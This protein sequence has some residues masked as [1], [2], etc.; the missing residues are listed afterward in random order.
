MEEVDDGDEAHERAPPCTPPPSHRTPPR[1]S[2]HSSSVESTPLSSHSSHS[3]H[4]SSSS[5][6][7]VAEGRRIGQTT[8]GHAASTVSAYKT[9]EKWV[10]AALRHLGHATRDELVLNLDSSCDPND[11]LASQ[12]I[13]MV[14]GWHKARTTA[15]EVGAVCFRKADAARPPQKDILRLVYAC[16]RGHI[17]GVRADHGISMIPD[18]KW[19]QKLAGARHNARVVSENNLANRTSD[20]SAFR[21][22]ADVSITPQQAMAMILPAL[23][24]NRRV[25][26]DPLNAVETGA[27]FAVFLTTGA[28]T[29]E[30][31]GCHLQS[32]GVETIDFA[33]GGGTTWDSVFF[34]ALYTKTGNDHR[35]SFLA[36]SNP[37]MCGVGG[38]GMSIL[39]R[40]ARYGHGPPLSM[41]VD[42]NSWKLFV[43]T[44][45]TKRYEK[46]FNNLYEIARVA[47]QKRDNLTYAGRHIGT[48]DLQH[49]GGTAEGG[50][51]RRNHKQGNAAHHYITIPL[52]DQ[53]SLAGNYRD[54]RAFVPAHLV[55]SLHGAV[56]V[57]LRLLYPTLFAHREWIAR[58]HDEI[59]AARGDRV[60]MR[61]DLR[62]C[63]LDRFVAGQMYCCRVALLCLTA[64]PRTNNRWAIDDTQP[65]VWD[66]WRGG[67]DVPAIDVLVQGRQDV[68]D[69]MDALAVDVRE[70]E[71]A[72]ARAR[73]SSPTDASTHAMASTLREVAEEQRLKNEWFMNQQRMRDEHLFARFA[74][75]SSVPVAPFP[76]MPPPPVRASAPP[77]SLRPTCLPTP[78]ASC[79][80]KRKRDEVDAGVIVPLSSWTTVADAVQYARTHIADREREGSHWRLLRKPNGDK[81]HSVNKH[82]LRYRQVCIAVGLTSCEAAQT[83]YRASG[84]SITKWADKLIDVNAAR[85]AHPSDLEMAAKRVMGL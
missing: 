3:S 57:V 45:D 37:W 43:T 36:N 70:S 28:R 56:D 49:S 12:V 64:H 58:K 78:A 2:S 66:Q 69:A 32:L 62:L 33:A 13:A 48:R 34:T 76:P 7:R 27:S 50:A 15:A 44:G 75:T 17:N 65:T 47:R 40:V 53:L 46:R 16:L 83:E 74:N 24:G 51:A 19:A 85:C 8:Q 26:A 10:D 39:M 20:G 5:G 55:R 52:A 63:D 1:S 14:T 31:T 41:N 35:N 18:D 54:E 21:H 59:D 42:A 71:V 73:A 72:E 6:G 68:V 38:I 81:D 61:T 77:A 60:Q 29:A 82:Y 84:A 79:K 23:T 80:P 4:S 9:A 22:K 25:D 67:E 30:L 11:A